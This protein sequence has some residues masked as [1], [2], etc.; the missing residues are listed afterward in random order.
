[1][2]LGAL[3]F[4]SPG[5]NT[6]GQPEVF[7]ASIN[8]GDGTTSA[9]TIAETPGGSGVPTL[10]SVA[11]SHLF[12]PGNTYTVTV[13][14][15]D[16]TDAQVKSA[17]FQVTM[18][19]PI[20]TVSA[21][22]DQ[23]AAEGAPVSIAATFTDNG[24]P[25][26]HAATINWGD[27]TVS[28]ATVG[29]PASAFD[30]GSATGTH[31]YG[32]PGYYTVTVSVAEGSFPATTS[33]LHVTVYDVA[34]TVAPIADVAAGIGVP[35][36]FST[37]FSDP[38]FPVGN[39]QESFT[40]TINWGDNTSTPGTVTVTPG[41]PGTPTTGIVTGLHHYSGDGPYIVT[42]TVSDGILS[43]ATSFHVTDAPPVV[44]PGPNL[45]GNEGSPVTLSAS[46]SDLGFNYN[47]VVKSFTASIDWGDNTSS[48]GTVIVT[49]GNATTP[50][51]GTISAI[52]T[53]ATFG[54][55]PVVIHLKDEAGVDGDGTESAVIGDVAPTVAALPGGSFTAH[56]NF[57]LNGV[58]N[59]VGVGDTH[60][61][62]IN[63][64]DGASTTLVDNAL[65]PDGNA[66]L[67]E[68]TSSVAGAY[69][70][71][72]F[73]TDATP[74]IVSVTVSDN[75]GL[76]ASTSAVYVPLA[77]LT[78]QSSGNVTLAG[79]APVVLTASANL[80]NSY[81]PS[82]GS[83]THLLSLDGQFFYVANAAARSIAIYQV[84]PTTGQQTAVGTFSDPSHNVFQTLA[85]NAG[86]TMAYAAGVD[87]VESLQR[88]RHDGTW[89]DVQCLRIPAQQ[90]RLVHEP[91]RQPGRH[92][93]LRGQSEP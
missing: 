47:G 65:S 66:P 77:A 86:G 57:V 31:D 17:T 70:A 39:Q 61:I 10:G 33:V 24:A 60:T 3:N 78:V 1:M 45:A 50:T 69:N 15:T 90:H 25:A 23:T 55:F 6:P 26:M 19:Q 51:M 48:L 9:G 30:T 54:A 58:F 73:Y 11:G 52:H 82:S 4:T 81:Q 72:H 5:Y 18:A 34:P 20:V 49:P 80:E 91:R 71:T 35:V 63:W 53:Y 46:F 64:G 7:T 36:P 89:L 22:P 44:V 41:S 38:T 59:D 2:S 56:S 8:W 14:I 21:G 92:A 93:P 32:L 79:S 75:G 43:G 85:M 13:T 29:E 28:S 62:T 88:G 68:P 84:N 87:G 83:T 40:A 27:G 37:T 76:S 67:T 42:V 16:T 74:K 12:A